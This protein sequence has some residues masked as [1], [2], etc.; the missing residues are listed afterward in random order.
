MTDYD[1]GCNNFVLLLART[2]EWCEEIKLTSWRLV[3]LVVLSPH[4]D[5]DRFVNCPPN[6]RRE[7]FTRQTKGHAVK[8]SRNTAPLMALSA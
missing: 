3:G 1:V 4:V 5:K 2:I 6:G 7:D 8:K